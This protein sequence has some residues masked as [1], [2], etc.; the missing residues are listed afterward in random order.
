[1]Q[2]VNI[3]KNGKLSN[4]VS[5]CYFFENLFNIYWYSGTKKA[6]IMT[7]LMIKRDIKNIELLTTRSLYLYKKVRLTT[8]YHQTDKLVVD[9][10][11]QYIPNHTH[12]CIVILQISRKQ[13]SLKDSN[14]HILVLAKEGTVLNKNL[15]HLQKKNY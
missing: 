14:L 7:I 4:T 2:F 12:K 9:F 8:K 15:K 13:Y 11:W 3:L 5:F 1:M 6:M 10:Q